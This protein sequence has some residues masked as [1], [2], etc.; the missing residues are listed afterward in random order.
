V[1]VSDSAT[2]TTIEKDYPSSQFSER[3]A[4]LGLGTAGKKDLAKL[5]I[6]GRVVVVFLSA[7][8]S[9]ISRTFNIYKYKY[10]QDTFFPDVIYVSKTTINFDW[11]D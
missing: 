5:K 6:T 11:M 10:L 4:D 1:A 2:A 8:S 3:I 7:E 9:T